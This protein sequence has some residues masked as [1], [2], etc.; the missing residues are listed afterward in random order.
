MQESVQLAG[1]VLA[2]GDST[3]M[4]TDKAMLPWPP[5]PQGPTDPPR[6]TLLSAAL[7]AFGAF[8][9]LNV[10]VAGGNADAVALTVGACGAHLVRNPTPEKGQFSSLQI[11]LRD[12]LDRGCN[13]AII[14]PVDCPPLNPSSLE[15][16]HHAF[17]GALTADFWAVA[18]EHDG[19]HGHPLLA[20]RDLIDAFLKA[21]ITGNAREVLHAHASRVV[22][23]PVPE[24]LAKAGLNTPQDYAAVEWNSPEI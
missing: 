11:G 20:N 16:L 5:P 6:H 15:R 24:S 1:L 9:R 21:P 4:G 19:K 2:A 3:R 17:L 22:Y 8:T 12:L 10:V 23:V 7:L 18:P 14:T 13:A